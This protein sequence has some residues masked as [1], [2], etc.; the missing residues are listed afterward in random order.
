MVLLQ[1]TLKGA[2]LDTAQIDFVPHLLRCQM[3]VEW[4]DTGC[5]SLTCYHTELHSIMNQV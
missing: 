2:D 3:D 4:S 1:I 5:G